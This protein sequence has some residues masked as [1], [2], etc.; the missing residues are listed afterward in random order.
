[1]LLFALI[2]LL[3]FFDYKSGCSKLFSFFLNGGKFQKLK[4]RY[5]LLQILRPEGSAIPIRIGRREYA[6]PFCP[7]KT[8]MNSHMEEHIRTHTGEK[9][10]PCPNEYCSY[11]AAQKSS[12]KKHIEICKFND[13]THLPVERPFACSYCPKRFSQK[14]N[15]TTHMKKIHLSKQLLNK[16]EQQQGGQ[17]YPAAEQTVKVEQEGHPDEQTDD[18]QQS[19]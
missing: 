6:C 15:C 18:Y 7:K 14:S 4:Y 19:E 3:H 12:L 5:L 8:I 13:L 16:L 10:F 11:A 1:M 17:L 2:F 9:P